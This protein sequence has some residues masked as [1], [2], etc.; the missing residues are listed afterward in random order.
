MLD[1]AW[2]SDRVLPRGGE[3]V[4]GEEK[5]GGEGGRLS[6]VERGAGTPPPLEQRNGGEEARKDDRKRGE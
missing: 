2:A 6:R 3:G 5:G 4:R 1:R